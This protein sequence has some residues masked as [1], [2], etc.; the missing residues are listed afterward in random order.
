M[1]TSRKQR[2]F[3]P[4]FYGTV[5]LAILTLLGR[6]AWEWWPTLRQAWS[7]RAFAR[8]LKNPDPEAR[9]RARA[10]LA[11]IGPASVPWLLE[12]ARDR[13][14]EARAAAFEALARIALAR[15][16]LSTIRTGLGD[17]DARVRRAAADCV[18]GFRSDVP[19]LADDMAKL[20]NDRHP[21]VR[22]RAAR[23][24]WWRKRQGT[25]A[26]IQALIA[27]AGSPDLPSDPGR[28]EVVTLI[29]KTGEMSQIRK[30]RLKDVAWSFGA[31][32]LSG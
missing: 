11:Q 3:G 2:L 31:A 23:A 29:Q 30:P 13:D 22:F 26:A 18:V 16:A 19:A 15:S 1:K 21:D 27:L 6:G 7:V 20:L 24:L 5:T 28:F 17:E 32:D 8:G 4:L 9:R 25:E 10:G 12:L 14:P